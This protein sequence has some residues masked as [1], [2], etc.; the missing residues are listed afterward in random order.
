MWFTNNG[1]HSIGRISTGGVVSH[2]TNPEIASPLGITAGPDGALWFDNVGNNSI[3]RITVDT[4]PA[5]VPDAPTR[6]RCDVGGLDRS[7]GGLHAGI[8][9]RSADHQLHGNMRVVG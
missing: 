9:R 8:Q 5:A 4:L 6:S 3:G 1:Y 2:Y 7:L